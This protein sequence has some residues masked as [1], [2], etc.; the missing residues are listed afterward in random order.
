MNVL[1]FDYGS[2]LIGV[3]LGNRLTAT[4]RPLGVVANGGNGPDWERID[5]WLREWQPEALLVGLPLTLDGEE[6]PASR[7]ARAFAN[8]LAKRSALPLHLVDE[9]RSSIEAARRFA[10]RRAAG[11]AKKKHAADIDAVA[12]EV[13]TETWLANPS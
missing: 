12:A 5:G 9:R 2:R 6:Q 8:A 11:L 4:A 13:I 1:G 7:G 3:A 10:Q